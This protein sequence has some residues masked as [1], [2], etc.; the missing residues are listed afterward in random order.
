MCAFVCTQTLPEDCP[1]RTICQLR[2]GDAEEGSLITVNVK[3]TPGSSH[4]L[5]DRAPRNIGHVRLASA[6]KHSQAVPIQTLPTV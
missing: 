1:Y 3:C 4:N 5:G 2:P 6:D